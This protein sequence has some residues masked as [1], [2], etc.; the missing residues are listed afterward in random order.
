MT[1]PV[2]LKKIDPFFARVEDEYKPPTRDS[3][4]ANNQDR[5]LA[6]EAAILA[7]GATAGYLGSKIFPSSTA[8]VKSE[9]QLSNMLA[10][11]S[12]VAQQL[13]TSRAPFV[14]A[15]SASEAAQ[16]ELAR[17][18]MLMEIVTKRAM[19][20]GIDPTDFVKSPELFAKAM[21]PEAGFAGKNWVK[22]QY[23]NVNP[24]LE[25]RLVGTGDAK[26]MVKNFMATKPR[27]D[28]AIGPS[29]QAESGI[30]RPA[31]RS[32]EAT[33]AGMMVGNIDK[34]LQEA[35]IAREA[36]QAAE[37]AAQ[38]GVDPRLQTEANKLER[39][40]AGQKADMATAAAKG[41]GAL[42]RM[43]MMLSGPKVGAGLGALSAYSLPEAYRAFQKGD[44]PKAATRGLEGVSG[45]LMLAPHPIAKALGLAAMAPA[46][47]YE[48]GPI[49]YGAAQKAFSSSPKK[50]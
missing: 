43:S 42:D 1:E 41:P 25:S 29:V 5:N 49:L 18:R 23:G 19:E 39:Q 44:Y 34:T 46:L 12:T 14:A 21:S 48:Y 8:D 37:A 4:D 30:L 10:Q 47:A 9:R 28:A 3:N 50:P 32:P 31:G 11:Q 20:L 22:A 35:I 7:G 15:K 6:V 17:N 16:L 36:A 24:I 40:I 38:S 33:R 26:E 2:D 27:A 13:E 45:A